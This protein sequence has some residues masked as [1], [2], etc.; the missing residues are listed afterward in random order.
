VLLNG[1][2]LI[3]LKMLISHL[4]RVIKVDGRIAGVKEIHESDRGRARFIVLTLMAFVFIGVGIFLL[5]RSFPLTAPDPDF[6]KR[7]WPALFLIVIGYVFAVAGLFAHK[8]LL[9]T[10]RSFAKGIGRAGQ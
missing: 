9:A 10:F 5:Q 1:G 7:S 4:G 6:F 3:T 8:E 2:D